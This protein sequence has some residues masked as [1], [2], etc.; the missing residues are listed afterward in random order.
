MPVE[1]HNHSGVCTVIAGSRMAARGI[2]SSWRSIS[3][4]LVR[5]LVTPAIALNSPPAMVVGTLIWRTFGAFISSATPITAPI[6]SISST[7]RTSLARQSCT[8]LAPSVIDP[9]YRDDKVGIDSAR[10][11]GGGDDGF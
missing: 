8:A 11:F 6:L 2:T 9:A 7:L 10:L 1:S 3:L 4:T 5:A